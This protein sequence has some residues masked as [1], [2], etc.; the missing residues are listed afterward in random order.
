VFIIIIIIPTNAHVSNLKLIL[1]YSD[2]FRSFY[3]I[4]REFTVV[5][6]KV[7]NYYNDKIQYSS[8]NDQILP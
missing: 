8:T 1:N 7:I 6:A 2:M 5:L 3:T 4:F